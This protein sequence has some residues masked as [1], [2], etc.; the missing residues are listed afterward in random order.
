MIWNVLRKEIMAN[1]TSPKVMITYVVCFVLILTSI[2]S[3]AVN[4]TSAVAENKATV[5]NERDRLTK[6][7]NY[8][9]DFMYQGVALYREP[10][11]LSVLV[12]GVEGDSARRAT[13]TTV[14]APFFDVSKFN[15]TP[16]LALFGFLDLE[17]IVKMILS[18]FA[19]LFTYDAIS[20]EKE[21][22]TLKLNLSN[23]IKRSSFIIGKFI[24]NFFLLIIP[25]VIPL[26]IGLLILLTFFPS[27]QFSGEEWSRI[28]VIILGFILY[29]I[30]FYSL[31]LMVSALTKNSNVS[32][33]I[34][35]MLWVLF[36]AVI[37]RLA[38]LAAQGMEPVPPVEEVRAELLALYGDKNG[39][40][41]DKLAEMQRGW[42]AE[43][44][45]KRPSKPLIST[46]K[47][48][49]EYEAKMAKHQ[50]WI[51]T[52]QARAQ[53]EIKDLINTTFDGVRRKSADMV[54]IQDMKQ[55]KQNAIAVSISRLTTPAAALTFISNRMARV[56]VFSSDESFRDACIQMQEAFVANNYEFLEDHPELMN[57][58][59]TQSEAIDVSHM[60]PDVRNFRKESFS[61]SFNAIIFDMSVL[62]LM[63]LVFIA[64]AFMAFLRYDVR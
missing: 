50:E 8:Q 44:A 18:L 52:L 16:V 9:Q 58:G 13:L 14:F 27:I 30:V 47:T 43:E 6:I 59:Q 40:M 62:V 4:Y 64:V 32:F 49:A 28:G 57:F 20:G 46:A 39:E 34:L 36:I 26:L 41:A 42:V 38:V 12:S 11:V 23:E 51:K 31:G 48:Q 21:L 1:I 10:S 53:E 15:S 3:G 54:K 5:A 56:G 60:Y 7:F 63:S 17:F 2:I 24:G 45:Q 37:P 19:I 61:E 35:L 29:L 25:F 33:L 55:D 22:G